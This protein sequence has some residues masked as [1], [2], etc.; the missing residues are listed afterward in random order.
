MSIVDVFGEY[1]DKLCD[2]DQKK[3]RA[4][5]RTGW[6]YQDLKFKFFPD[7]RLLPADPADDGY[8]AQA[9]QDS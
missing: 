5:L 3:A 6:Q 4:L 9:S 2:K 7:R 1:V 8:H